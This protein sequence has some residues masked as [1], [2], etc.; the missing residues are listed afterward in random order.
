M[1]FDLVPKNFWN[2]HVPSRM[3]SFIDDLDEWTN[4]I[5]T[6]GLTVSEDDNNIY[7]EAQVPGVDP[8]NIEV[9]VNKG[10]LWIKGRQDETEEDKKRKYYKRA[11]SQFSYHVSLP[12]SVDPVAEP[13]AN[14]KNGMIKIRLQKSIQEQPKKIHIKSE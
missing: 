11:S 6:T 1:V 7:V 8:K 3:S 10:M 2:F 13:D 14:I 4:Y 9:T 12:N 5:P